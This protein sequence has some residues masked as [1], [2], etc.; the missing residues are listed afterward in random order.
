MSWLD[1]LQQ[2]WNAKNTWQVVAILFTFICTGFTILFI[3]RPVLAFLFGHDIPTLAKVIYY[4]LILPIYNLF[5][6]AYGFL[7]GQFNFFLQ[8]EKRFFARIASYFKKK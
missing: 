2:R 6:L 8:F 4:I 5:L 7:F 1:R 3:K